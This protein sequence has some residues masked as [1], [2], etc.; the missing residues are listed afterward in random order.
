M[1]SPKSLPSM[2]L[3]EQRSSLT[4]DPSLLTELLPLFP[5]PTSRGF[6]FADIDSDDSL[7]AITTG[8]RVNKYKRIMEQTRAQ[9]AGRNRSC[10][11]AKKSMY[12]RQTDRSKSTKHRYSEGSRKNSTTRQKNGIGEK[13]AEQ[14]APFRKFEGKNTMQQQQNLDH[15]HSRTR[16]TYF[17]NERELIDNFPPMPQEIRINRIVGEYDGYDGRYNKYKE[18]LS[19][20]R[21]K[22]HCEEAE[23]EMRS[24]SSH[25]R[26][27]S[28]SQDNSTQ[29]FSTSSR[30]T[31]SGK[32]SKASNKS[33]ATKLTSIASSLKTG[34][35]ASEVLAFGAVVEHLTKGGSLMSAKK[36]FQKEVHNLDKYKSVDSYKSSKSR[37]RNA[38]L[39]GKLLN[40]KISNDEKSMELALDN[41]TLLE[42]LSLD[43]KVH[44]G[45]KA[46]TVKK[47]DDSI[48]TAKGDKYITK[49]KDQ[50]E[51]EDD[52]C[53]KFTKAPKKEKDGAT[54]DVGTKIA[55]KVPV[56]LEDDGTVGSNTNF[57][58]T[59]C[60]T[61]FGSGSETE[62]YS[63][64]SDS[65]GTYTY[66]A[67]DD[68]AT[69][70]TYSSCS[71]DRKHHRKKTKNFFRMLKG[72]K[73]TKKRKSDNR[74]LFQV[75]RL[76]D[77][78][79]DENDENA[80]TGNHS[81]RT[82]VRSRGSEYRKEK[83]KMENVE[84]RTLKGSDHGMGWKI[85]ISNLDK[86]IGAKVETSG[87]HSKD[88][89]AEKSLVSCESENDEDSICGGSIAMESI[90]SL[91]ETIESLIGGLE[92]VAKFATDS[93][94]SARS[95]L[96]PDENDEFPGM[97]AADE[98][99]AEIKTIEEP[100]E[101][102][103]VPEE[104]EP[105][106]TAI[107]PENPPCQSSESAR[108]E[109]DAKEIPEEK[110]EEVSSSKTGAKMSIQRIASVGVSKKP[111][112]FRK[113]MSFLKSKKP[114]AQTKSYENDLY[115]DENESYE[116]VIDV[117]NRE[118]ESIE[119]EKKEK[120]DIHGVKANENIS[121]EMFLDP[122]PLMDIE[123]EEPA[124]NR[125]ASGEKKKPSI[126][127]NAPTSTEKMMADLLST[128]QMCCG[129]VSIDQKVIASSLQKQLETAR[130]KIVL[131]CD[132][133]QLGRNPDIDPKE[134]VV[135]PLDNRDAFIRNVPTDE[136]E[137]KRR[138]PAR[139]LSPINRNYKNHKKNRNLQYPIIARRKRSQASF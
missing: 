22:V 77:S 35:S 9:H 31:R 110:N 119:N 101:N 87:A 105:K 72:K 100:E 75:D 123:E 51:E 117:Y 71:T 44:D 43:D 122:K 29:Y 125:M 111:K 109:P 4:D 85:G 59:I 34:A 14:Y 19:Q 10:S 135:R 106:S 6:G 54:N 118:T 21:R 86:V 136:R 28:D 80:N 91:D 60:E 84:A 58:E 74:R 97:T 103:I 27:M 52:W 70:R 3:I 30:S 50:E 121:T 63:C 23:T 55:S 38:E 26:L 76:P 94:R 139:H 39:R 127:L 66:N 5:E 64:E 56:T 47:G 36:V 62:S 95:I 45:N 99:E 73:R 81:K 134:T 138:Q 49:I 92:N 116:V 93:M 128:G 104:R 126:V 53:F 113:K 107:T 68:T 40:T 67:D 98:F 115:I 129:K 102:A 112:L 15:Y 46:K 120:N 89:E 7:E 48:S 24:S 16:P 61:S 132:N 1:S 114:E 13:F 108:E 57:D 37:G 82:S 42:E 131:S 18:T 90:T 41:I 65:E 33:N 130:G 133:L 96:F 83:G 88:N 2:V 17:K 25:A 79:D 8:K 20:H 137:N 78:F 11:P 32:F 12:N 124:H 69:Y